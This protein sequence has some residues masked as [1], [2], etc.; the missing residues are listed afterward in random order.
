[1]RKG[2]K[3][4]QKNWMLVYAW[5]F[6][7]Y[8]TLYIARPICDFLKA[9]VAFSAFV[10]ILCI[11]LGAAALIGVVKKAKVFNALSYVLLAVVLVSYANGLMTLQYPEEKIHFIEYGVLAFLV[12]RALALG[13]HSPK[14]YAQS[15]V[16]VTVLGLVDEGIQYLLPNRYFQVEDVV[17]NSI[18]GGLGLLIVYI[19]H[20]DH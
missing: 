15:F 14:A 18:S 7:I 8:S 13:A 12:Y 9:T 2:R 20:K 5:V 16:I 17:L 3:E 6:L 4:R 1:M 10:D 19:L 11:G